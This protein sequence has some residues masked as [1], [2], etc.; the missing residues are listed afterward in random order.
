MAKKHLAN[1][2]HLPT[3]PAEHIFKRTIQ[4]NSWASLIDLTTEC[5]TLCL[6]STLSRTPLSALSKRIA[7]CTTGPLISCNQVVML[8]HATPKSTL[9]SVL[10]QT[11]SVCTVYLVSTLLKVLAKPPNLSNFCRNVSIY[12][13]PSTRIAHTINVPTKC[14][15]HDTCHQCSI[16][17]PQ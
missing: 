15:T 9:P 7:E 12:Q 3:H 16:T 1:K 5:T 11:S 14:S 10:Q 2:A 8:H 6:L 4:R 17:L 13:E